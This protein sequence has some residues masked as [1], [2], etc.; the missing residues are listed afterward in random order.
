MAVLD[1]ASARASALNYK[2]RNPPNAVVDRGINMRNGHPVPSP[3]HLKPYRPDVSFARPEWD[4]V[5]AREH[6]M[7]NII[8]L[9]GATYNIRERD[10][11]SQM[12]FADRALPRQVAMWLCR[13]LTAHT[14]KE[15]GV[16][17]GGRDHSTVSHA[18]DKIELLRQTD[19]TL[20]AKLNQFISIIDPMRAA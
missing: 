11:I 17:F 1:F 14:F 7:I 15:I 16:R 12:R 8:R 3:G 20:N 5:I 9:V 10:L 18:V 2:L 13:K 4:P 19:E 6:T